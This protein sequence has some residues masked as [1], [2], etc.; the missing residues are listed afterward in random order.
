MVSIFDFGIGGIRDETWLLGSETN[1]ISSL[2]KEI[3]LTLGRFTVFEESS[4]AG[5]DTPSGTPPDYRIK[6]Q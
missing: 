1:E 2:S 3:S 5:P 4:F 6:L